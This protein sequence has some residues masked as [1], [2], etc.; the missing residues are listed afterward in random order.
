MLWYHRADRNP[1]FMISSGKLESHWFRDGCMTLGLT[2]TLVVK[3]GGSLGSSWMMFHLVLGSRHFMTVSVFKDNQGSW[4][5]IVY[6]GFLRSLRRPSAKLV[7]LLIWVIRIVTAASL[8]NIVWA[9]NDCFAW[10]VHGN[11]QLNVFI[12][13]CVLLMPLVYWSSD[14]FVIGSLEATFF[15]LG[16]FSASR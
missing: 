16:W 8:T 11:I 4:A 12:R 13:M 5:V 14:V 10:W 9:F 3:G 2:L 7:S 6:C 1:Y 15:G